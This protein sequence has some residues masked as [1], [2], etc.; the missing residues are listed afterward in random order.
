MEPTT[1]LPTR[2]GA[3]LRTGPLLH[4]KD[5]LKVLIETGYTEE[6][7]AATIGLSHPGDTLD[8]P[9]A[10][11]RAASSQ[12]YDVL[13]R[14]F[15]LKQTVERGAV[16]R[17]VSPAL[18]RELVDCGLLLPVAG[19]LGSAVKILPFGDLMCVADFGRSESGCDVSPDHVLGVGPASVTVAKLTVPRPG[20]DVFDLGCGSGIQSLLAAATA[21]RVVGTDTNPRALNMARFNAHLNGLANIEWREGSFFEPVEGEAFDGIVANPP[22]VISPRG[23]YLFCDSELTGDGVSEHVINRSAMHLKEGG[24]ATVLF[25]W[26][27]EG[28]EDWERRPFEWCEG[29]GCDCWLVRSGNAEPLTYAANWLRQAG[30]RDGSQYGELIDEWLAY[31]ERLGIKSF[32]SGA[33]IL[34]K[35]SAAR[36]WRR[37]DSMDVGR[38]TLQSGGHIER[39]FALETLVQEEGDEGLLNRVLQVHPDTYLHQELGWNVDGWSLR[40]VSVGLNKGLPFAG[41]GDAAVIRLLTNCRGEQTLR[42]VMGKLAEE[43]ET[44]LET[45]AP[46]ILNV[47]RKMVRSGILVPAYRS[48][49]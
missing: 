42:S 5:L 21:K 25:N 30:Q 17:A 16:E 28:G 43:M 19:G 45:V 44:P 23:K 48:S 46:T 2:A 20:G 31:Y 27:Y 4:P 38:S 47:V 33:M 9:L 3:P 26:H 6:R 8:L 18:C 37:A 24:F 13:V 14:L 29:N 12:P 49:P 1:Q 32:C 10:L 7:L 15:L 11:K 40:V 36:N 35:R 34:R 41:D 22:F 39:L